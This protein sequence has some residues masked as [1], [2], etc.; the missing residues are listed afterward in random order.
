[1]LD[2][3]AFGCGWQSVAAMVLAA[4][5][6]IDCRTWLFANVGDDSEDPA[7]IRYLREHAIP[8]AERH[9]LDLKVL[10]RTRRDGTVETLYQ[11]LT[12]PG[13]RSIPIP[14]RMPGGAPGTRS[15]TSDFKIKV[16]GRELKARGATAEHPWTLGIGISVDEIHRAN[17]R[18]SEPYE[19]LVYPLLDL[20]VRR[21]DCPRIIRS[22]GLPVP[23]RSA[24]W[25]CPNKRLQSWADQR[26]DN[27]NLFAR[28]CRLEQ[29]I[30][31]RRQVL[32][33][34]PVYFTGVGRPLAEAVND[35][36]VLP[37]EAADGGCDSG[38]CFT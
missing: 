34:D 25:F 26:R 28:S 35:D 30:N 23:P 21:A 33:R 29:Q 18:R 32:H 8:F 12:R 27:P 15:C 17:N 5:G 19:R 16:T 7:T 3:F 14:V 22:A 11:R 9:G 6:D 13:S 20:G 36:P 31:V 24:C 2:A 1:V 10:H 37:L 4:R 38:W